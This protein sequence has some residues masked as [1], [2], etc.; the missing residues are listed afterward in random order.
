MEEQQ[1]NEQQQGH[2]DQPNDAGQTGQTDGSSQSAETGQETNQQSGGQQMN[3]QQQQQ[4][5]P[6]GRPQDMPAYKKDESM[7]IQLTHLSSLTTY[8]FPMANILAPII[9]LSMKK[10]EYPAVEPHAKDVLNFNI[11]FTI[12]YGIGW[13]LTLFSFGLLFMVPIV[14]HILHIAFT[15]MAVMKVNEGKPYKYPMTLRLVT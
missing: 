15:I 2:T 10:D 1:S 8:I 7:W 3:Q 14:I 6:P 12:W 11:S 13:V 9:I 4:V 5:P